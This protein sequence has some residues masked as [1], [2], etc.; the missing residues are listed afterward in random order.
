LTCAANV[1]LAGDWPM[2]AHDARRAGATPEVVRPPFRRRWYRNFADE[3][4][5]QGTQPVIAGGKV[6]IGTMHGILHAIDAATG[7]DAWT[8]KVPGGVFHAAAVADGAVYVT[9]GRGQLHAV[10]AATGKARWVFDPASGVAIWS[11]PLPFEGRVY[12]G[13]RDGFLYA[14]NAAD[15]TLAWKAGVGAPIVHS[16]AIDPETRRLYVGAEDMCGYAFDLGSGK[17]LWRSQRMHGYTFA[18]YYPVVVPEGGVV[19]TTR[20]FNR[21]HE[22]EANKAFDALGKAF[23][24][25]VRNDRDPKDRRTYP[26]MPNWRFS[27]EL[28]KRL[29]AAVRRRYKQPGLWDR[30]FAFIRQQL[31]AHPHRQTVFLLDGA[32]GRS[33]GVVPVIYAESNNGTCAPPIVMAN[34][35]VVIQIEAGLLHSRH[36]DVGYIDANTGDIQLVQPP[37][38]RHRNGTG[39]HI[40]PDEQAALSAAGSVLI[41]SRQDRVHGFDASGRIRNVGETWIRNIHW[42]QADE[43][44]HLPLRILRGEPLPVGREYVG[45]AFGV[46][47]G[48]SGI[49]TPSAVANKTLYYISQH[50]GN[51]GACLMAYE[52]TGRRVG[53]RE[54]VRTRDVTDADRKAAIESK[55]NYDYVSARGKRSKLLEALEVRVPGTLGNADPAGIGAGK[56]PSEAELEKILFEASRDVRPSPA[57][58]LRARLAAAVEELVSADWAP[59]AFPEGKFPGEGYWAY[60]D[61]A[62]LFYAL[63]LAWPYL[64]RELQARAQAYAR[65]HLDRDNP[66]FARFLPVGRGQRRERYASAHFQRTAHCRLRELGLPRLYPLWLYAWASGDWT[67]VEAHWQD[68]KDVLTRSQPPEWQ[69]D[70]KNGCLSGLIAYCRMAAHVK[71]NEA[72]EAAKPRALAAMR[73]R[74]EYEATMTRGG[75]YYYCASGMLRSGPA[76][77]TFLTPEI[78]RLCRAYAAE[79]QNALVA[80]Y[81]DYHKPTWYMAWGILACYGH[82]NCCEMPIHTI[83]HFQAKAFLVD[84]PADELAHAVDVPWCRADLYHIEKLALAIRAS[85][86]IAWHDVRSPSGVER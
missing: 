33:R 32:T 44:V 82:E 26:A 11:S 80:R 42:P 56:K 30:Q 43:V 7:K 23:Y 22:G 13:G 6:F 37:D 78:G 34:G 51:T 62:E 57:P 77:W 53:L 41:V 40:I 29:E 76:R 2:L 35:R 15:G 3:G 18:G 73:E 55:W 45:R 17:R 16:P 20:P 28:N 5:M 74:I 8:Y 65:A 10:D 68:F 69:A 75:V 27:R 25:A 66:I 63:G 59:L 46:Y 50:E 85:G 38:D 52:M 21:G 31:V 67:F 60:G 36:K 48:G 1:A 61:P 71:D 64:P 54:P 12:F 83:S 47:G 70:G 14:V 9:S 58:P 4:L 86:K 49:D 24:G 39:L 72:L 84:T 81:I 19:F 79:V